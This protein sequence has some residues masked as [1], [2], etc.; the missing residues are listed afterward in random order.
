MMIMIDKKELD[1]FAQDI[2]IAYKN[3]SILKQVSKV[4]DYY[5]DCK[6]NFFQIGERTL[7]PK[8]FFSLGNNVDN[9][10]LSK[11]FAR[12]IVFGEKNFILSK[13]IELSQENKIPLVPI[14]E[15]SY[16]EIVQAILRNVDNPTD[17]FVPIDE[18]YYNEVHDWLYKNNA[19]YKDDLYIIVGNSRIKVHWS[20]KYTPLNHVVV[21]NKDGLIV[22]QKKFN[23]MLEPKGL[24][25]PI[26]KY[27]EEEPIRVDIAESRDP[28]KLDVLFRTVIAIENVKERSACVIKLPN[29]ESL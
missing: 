21:S 11:D 7:I 12:S 4:I 25:T 6:S 20:T 28:D 19:E 5:K 15:F 24:G 9:S 3:T 29:R 17:I 10:M 22:V 27:G 23:E 14:S 16:P 2:I 13:L 18:P 26:Q 8:D 1:E